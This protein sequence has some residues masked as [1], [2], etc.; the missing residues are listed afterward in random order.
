[1]ACQG[2]G[3]WFT[4]TLAGRG[5]AALPMKYG[6]DI[7]EGHSLLASMPVVKK[8]LGA[9]ILLTCLSMVSIILLLPSSI[10]SN[11][12]QKITVGY[13]I[14][15]YGKLFKWGT[16]DE[17]D[18]DEEAE[19]DGVRLVVFGDSWADGAVEKGEEGRG[20]GWTDVLCEEVRTRPFPL[21]LLQ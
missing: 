1:M 2:L 6:Q 8:R 14:D 15:D 16:E 18:D 20:K 12:L 21:D 5:V 4:V 3:S 10:V 17:L 9:S 7:L 19:D 13:G 11:H